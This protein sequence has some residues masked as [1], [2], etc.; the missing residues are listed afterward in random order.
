[1]QSPPPL[2][3]LHFLGFLLHYLD[4]GVINMSVSLQCDLDIDAKSVWHTISP[5]TTSKCSILYLQEAGDFWC[6]PNYYT[7]REGFSSYLMKLTLSGCGLLEYQGQ[8]YLVPTGHLFWIDCRKPQN[9]RTAPNAENWHVLWIHFFGANAQ[10]YYDT[11][12]KQNGGNP[13]VS[14][15]SNSP[16]FHLLPALLQ[17]D[18]SGANQQKTDFEA[19]SLLGQLISECVLCSMAS[20]HPEDIPQTIQ[21]VRQYLAKNYMQKIT[22]E[23][24]G[25]RFNLNPFYLQ[26]QFKRYV[27]QSPSEF[28]I[29][30][31]ITH[32]KELMRR[33]T[34][35]IGQI[36]REVGIHNL[37]YFTRQFK[38]QEGIT[39]QEYCKLWPIIE[40]T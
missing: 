20:R 13:V 17:L 25:N 8:Q 2:F 23:D 28:I 27:G 12:V 14:L 33:T 22:L 19:A 38:Q 39:P 36:A 26:K 31:R 7:S 3:P 21:S 18:A 29:H 10:F 34:K 15:P 4:I 30:L 5:T 6:G 40:E 32:A 37:G 1:M 11:F 24:L 9:Y 16:I 35:T